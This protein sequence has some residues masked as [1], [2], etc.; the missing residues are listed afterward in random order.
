MGRLEGRVT[1]VTGGSG[2]IGRGLCRALAREGATVA[3]SYKGNAKRA[4]SFRDELAALSPNTSSVQADISE[5]AQ[6]DHLFQSVEKKHGPVEILVNNAGPFVYKLMEK[7]SLEEWREVVE[8][9]ITGTFLCCRAALPAMKR[10]HW[11]RIINLTCTGAGRGLG[12]LKMTAYMAAKAG[13]AAFTQSL[14]LEVAH[15]GI[16]VNAVSPGIVEHYDLSFEEARKRP[17]KEQP[18]PRPSISA[19]L[20]RAVVF[21]ADPDADFITGTILDVTG[22]QLLYD[23]LHVEW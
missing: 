23:Q 21:L 18:V 14:A 3:F 10:A 4:Q 6:V 17:S 2:G 19:D 12:G 5:L 22:G 7:T 11:G 16:T 9:N 1:L 13:V 8:G 15:E 20:A